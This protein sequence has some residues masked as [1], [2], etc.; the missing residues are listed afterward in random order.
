MRKNIDFNNIIYH[1]FTNIIYNIIL[2]MIDSELVMVCHCPFPT[3]KQV[4]YI[5]DG[6]RV[7]RLGSDVKYVDPDSCPGNTWDKIEDNS[8]TYVWGIHCPIY[9]LFKHASYLKDNV[10]LGPLLDI[11]KNSWRVL[12]SNGLVIIPVPK[13]IE[14]ECQNE[15][16][17]VKTFIETDPRFNKWNVSIINSSENRFNLAYKNSINVVDIPRL[18]IVF[19][20]QPFGGKKKRN[21]RHRRN[22]K[23]KKTRRK[24]R[25]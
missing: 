6:R 10:V 2:V 19:K 21:T 18:L 25:I 14:N 24:Y 15:F 16:N 20:K 1:Y 8:K 3:H 9:L 11:L 13:S 7:K 4:Y 12:K 23:N 22:K 17:E 5:K